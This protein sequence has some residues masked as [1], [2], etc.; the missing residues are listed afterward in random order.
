MKTQTDKGSLPLIAGEFEK[1]SKGVNSAKGRWNLE[2][3]I[4]KVI[5]K[6]VVL[7]FLNH[8][9]SFDRGGAASI[10]VMK[11]LWKLSNEVAKVIETSFALGIDFKGRKD[12]ASEVIAR[13]EK[14]DEERFQDI[15]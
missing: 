2:E 7:G 13:R 11:S 9:K 5:E 1:G 10:Q 6:C 8:W 4:T 14:E 15:N 3:E 12:L